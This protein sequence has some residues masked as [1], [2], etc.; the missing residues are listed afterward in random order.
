MTRKTVGYVELE[1]RCPNCG[2]RN[3]GRARL[4]QSCGA[5]QPTDVQFEQPAEEK[6][7]QDGALAERA[8]SGPDIHCAFCGARNPG[9]AKSCSQCGADL[10]AGAARP[11]GQVL[12]AHRDK[13]APDVACDYCGSLNPATRTICA[14]C[15]ATLE[16]AGKPQPAPAP[17]RKGLGVGAVIAIVLIV[18][19]CIGL[20]TL[21]TRTDDVVG[22]VTDVS[23]ERQIVILGLQPVERS[24]WRDEI[25]SEADVG[26]CRSEVR[27]RQ[28]N[29]A[30]NAE[31]VC[32]T[33]Y[34]VD[35]GSG[36]GEVVQDCE[37]LLYDDRCSYTVL[38][39]AAVGVETLNGA[40][41]N[42]AWPVVF[43]EEE[44]LEGER[45]ETYKVTFS[46][47]GERY[48][49]TL[50]DPYEFAQF[51]RGSDWVLSVNA[52]KAVVDVAPAR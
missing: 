20:F 7:V 46:A 44:Q 11:G 35:T 37:Y 47:D 23:W 43:L 51:E 15:G 33:P 5:A 14:Q 29:P 19:A 40:D 3:P 36:I 25:P 12:G 49:Y 50:S 18:A 8:Q 39:W 38:D 52:F 48:S 17:A 30:P 41:L 45:K 1:W 27:S 10:Q 34:T 22:R 28:A 13:P 16:Q 42:P 6:V 26:A 32:G 4:C 9:D 21:F 2:R 31:E 24:A